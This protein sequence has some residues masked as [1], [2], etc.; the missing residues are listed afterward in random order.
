MTL[1]LPS[2]LLLHVRI[3]GMRNPNINVKTKLK[4]KMKNKKQNI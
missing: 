1:I 3:K 2:R 4:L